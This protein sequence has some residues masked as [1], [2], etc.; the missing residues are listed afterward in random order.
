MANWIP[1][2]YALTGSKEELQELEQNI[3]AAEE[4]ARKENKNQEQNI[5]D[6]E[7]LAKLLGRPFAYDDLLCYWYYRD[8]EYNALEWKATEDGEEYLQWEII[9]K[10][11][12]NP[13]V[14]EMIE[15][16]YT[17]IK[18][19]YWEDRDCDTND[20][21]HR[22]FKPLADESQEDFNSTGEV[23]SFN[24]DLGNKEES[25]ESDFPF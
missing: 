4:M 8:E 15:G 9:H 13:K 7:S 10:N 1:I 6:I 11:G 19:F 3:R 5:C 17:T 12:E 24:L 18:V 14:R 22:Y 25:A 20:N 2:T 16:A 23:K 21:E